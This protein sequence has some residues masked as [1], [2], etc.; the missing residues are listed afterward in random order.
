MGIEALLAAGFAA[1][2]GAGA[3][4]MSVMAAY[5]ATMRGLEEV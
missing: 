5:W 1:G 3:V 4:A 2:V